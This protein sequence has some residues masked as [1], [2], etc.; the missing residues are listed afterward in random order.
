M[1]RRRTELLQVILIVFVTL[2]GAGL[3]A[4]YFTWNDLGESLALLA[5][6]RPTR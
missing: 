6:K 1:Q 5:G 4:N 2:G 3:L